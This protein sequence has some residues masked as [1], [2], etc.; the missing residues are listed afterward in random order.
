LIDVVYFTTEQSFY[1]HRELRY[2][3]RSLVKHVSVADQVWVIGAKPSWLTLGAIHIPETDPYEH[4]KDANIIRKMVHTCRRTDISQPFLFVNDDHFFSQDCRAA[5]FPFYHK[6]EIRAAGANREYCRRLANTRRLLEAWG[7]GT[8]NFDVHTPILIHQDKFLEVFTTCDWVDLDG[9]G[10]VM[11]S[12]Y[13]NS[14]PEIVAAGVHLPDCKMTVRTGG[15]VDFWVEKLSWER[16]C[17]STGNYISRMVWQVLE[18]LYPEP[19]KFEM[20]GK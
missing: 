3:L 20:E 14:V 11:K 8:L 7:L 12:V 13:G 4:N 2:S 9:P 5:E 19:S 15:N 6:G 17:W 18:Q 1:G 16:P 10:L